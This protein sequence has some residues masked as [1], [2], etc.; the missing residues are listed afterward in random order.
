MRGD[1]TPRRE[2]LRRILSDGKARNQ[3][4]IVAALTASGFESTQATVSRD[5]R[6]LG[7]VKSRGSYSLPGARAGEGGPG[8][9]ELLAQSVLRIRSSGDA[10]IVI[11]TGTGLAARTGLAID[12]LN[13]E[14]VVGTIAG[15]DTVFVAA[16]GKKEQR[17]LLRR[18]E[19]IRKGG[20]S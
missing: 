19:A 11:Q 5:L 16:P 3:S 9:E 20:T 1:P 14:E 8:E 15:D 6:D 4:Q 12:R 7:A 13:W 18:I 10:L 2:A 17:S